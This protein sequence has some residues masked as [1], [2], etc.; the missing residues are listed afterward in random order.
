M[1][2]PDGAR[3]RRAGLPRSR[4]R[5]PWW[6]TAAAAAGSVLLLAACDP[7]PVSGELW[8]NPSASLPV[9]LAQA[10]AEGG[11]EEVVALLERLQ[12]PTATWF[13]GDEDD[14]RSA[15]GE[16][17]A[18]AGQAGQVPVI[19]LYNVPDRDC[20]LFSSGGAQD[21]DAYLSWVEQVHEGL[22]AGPVIVV[23]EP[24][25]VAQAR[26]ECVGRIDP[27]ERFAV[28]S[29][30]VGVLTQEPQ[31]RVYLDAGHADWVEDTAALAEDL[32]RSGVES[33]AGFSLNV[34][35]FQTTEASI[36]YGRSV[37]QALG[38]AGFVVDTSRNGAGPPVEDGSG[39]EWCNP[40]SARV[41]AGPTTDPGVDGVD[42][43]LWVKRPGDSDGDCRPGEPPAGTFTLDLALQLASD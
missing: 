4:A 24:D 6:W 28:L 31:R 20:G 25:A 26:T 42:A 11:G 10:R 27:G 41:G 33:A 36:A 12:Q 16:V 13:S 17:V 35:N 8:L 39:V 40:A 34:S 1:S 21:A 9:A 30:A 18:Q 32:R 23:L 7:D 38:G 19:A 29:R 3:R 43:Y 22:G 5:G 14:V 37:A 2:H 15:V